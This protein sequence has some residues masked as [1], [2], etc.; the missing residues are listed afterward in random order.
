MAVS[1]RSRSLRTSVRRR[2]NWEVGPRTSAGGGGQAISTSIAQIAGLAAQANIDGQTLIRTRGEVLMYLR[3]ASG[4][5]DG[6][7]GAFGIGKATLAAFTA[8]AASVPTPV[9]EEAWDGWLYH[10]YFALVSAGPIA[11]ATAA[12]EQLQVNNVVAALRFEVDSKAMRKIDADEVFY[13]AIEV[14]EVGTSDMVWNFNSRL[15]VKVMN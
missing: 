11:A 15:L 14:T 12:Q 1:R 9:T 8:G 4:Q 7:N 13:A 3:S 10:R 6:F 5:S 2:S